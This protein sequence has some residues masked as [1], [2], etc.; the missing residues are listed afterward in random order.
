MVVRRLP[1]HLCH[2]GIKNQHWGV[3]NGPPYPL[4]RKL[5]RRIKAGHNEN[6]YEGKKVGT[7][8]SAGILGDHY[9]VPIS[10]SN[11]EWEKIYK[12]ED[13]R[14]KYRATDLGLKD[15]N[16]YADGNYRNALE[17][18]DVRSLVE[19]NF[20]N[21]DSKNS[22]LSL[23][24]NL[25]MGI[26]Q[27]GFR[28]N[29]GLINAINNTSIDRLKPETLNNCS[30]CS[31]MVELVQRG[32]NPRTFS[33]GRCKFGMLNTATQ[34]H[35]DG[36]IPY[37]EKSYENI[38]RRIKSFGNKGSGT[39]GIRRAD[40]SGHSMHFTTVKGGRIE[41]QDGQNGRVY[42]NL[43][44]ALKAEHHDPNQFCH[45]TRLDCATPNVKHM[46]EDSVVR[47]DKDINN[48]ERWPSGVQFK[49]SG[50]NIWINEYDSM[51]SFNGKTSTMIKEKLEDYYNSRKR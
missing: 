48:Y 27:N 35:W 51:D 10:M 44:D 22:L 37:K 13:L 43:V 31:D 9:T 6:R 24:H 14:K 20:K 41:V 23:D 26:R 47:M 7:Q 4:D 15:V 28:N 17:C 3:R 49:E 38:E 50:N 34:Y 33:A 21:E 42:D 46:I 8:H 30:K 5:S 12:T 18:S 16:Q 19:S 39:I 45:I 32:L 36:S 40:G 11:S 2:H 29:P 25:V 1:N